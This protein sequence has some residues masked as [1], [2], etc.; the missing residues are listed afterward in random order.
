[1]E[2]YPEC[3][4]MSKVKKQSQ[5]VGEFLDWLVNERE[6]VLSEYHEGEG[7]NDEEVLMPISVKIEKLL[8]EFFEI[9][10]NKVEQERRQ[11]IEEI[12]N[13]EQRSKVL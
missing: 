5:L 2:N 1:M 3:E 7:R 13:E 8:A 12:R 4:K 10:L 9:D 6:I 11:M